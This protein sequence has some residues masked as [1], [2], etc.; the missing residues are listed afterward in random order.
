MTTLYNLVLN[1]T[2][3]QERVFHGKTI[4]V[5][6]LLKKLNSILLYRTMN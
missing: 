1:N 3:V 6:E 2:E 4:G 5:E